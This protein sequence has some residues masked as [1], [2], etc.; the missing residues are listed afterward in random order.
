M[1]IGL[2][3]DLQTDPHDPRQAEFD[4]QA[5]IEALRQALESLGHHVTLLGGPEDLLR[6]GPTQCCDVDLVF[7][8][9]EGGWGRCR[10]AWAPILLDLYRIPYVGSDALT[11]SIGLDKVV[12]KR[13]AMA[14]GIPTPRWIAIDHPGALA[15]KVP[16]TFPVIVKPRWQG[17][18]RGL[19]AGAVVNDQT[20]LTARV[21]WLY[22]R[23]PEPI[24]IEEFIDYGELTVCVIGNDPP[25]AYPAI[26]RPIDTATRLSCHLITPSSSQWECPIE[27]DERLDA[28]ARDIAIA[29][30]KVLGVQDMARVDLRV[31]RNGQ[32]FF[33]EIN[34]LPSFDPA[35]SLG[36]L[37]EYLGVTYAILIGRILD[38]ALLRLGYLVNATRCDPIPYK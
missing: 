30:V 10:E 16:L 18:G 25:V 31:D 8:I 38:A 12:S 32:L 29:M 17:S 5:T 11:L 1:D 22:A 33:L 6:S 2:V 26:Q 21:S 35:G 36:L 34:P 28:R 27:L 37:A 23:C 4:P 3:F 14:E 15:A 13:L 24:V 20:A 19:D 7:N 9:A